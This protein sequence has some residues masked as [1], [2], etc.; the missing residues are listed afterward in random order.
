MK[1]SITLVLLTAWAVLAAAVCQADEAKEQELLAVLRSE[2]P[3][4][5]KAIACKLLA[6]HGSGAAAADLAPLLSN[7][8]L[9]S[10]ARI[11]LEAIPG[12]EADEALR[13]ATESLDGLLLV[14]VINSIGVR[15]DAQAV[16]SLAKQL[17][18][19]DAEVASAA[20]VA[21]GRIGNDG[22]VQTLRQALRNA[23]GEV[24]SA[25]AEGCVLSAERRL[26]EGK[27][28][29]AAE[30]YDE[31]RQAEVPQQRV[32]EATR[33]AIL[34]RGDEGVPLLLEQLRSPERKF[35]QMAL[36]TA[37]EF[38]GEQVDQALAQEITRAEPERAALII[39]AAADRPETV[40]L[41]AVLQA[42][43]QGAKPV[44]LSAI[45]ALQRVGDDSCLAALLKIATDADPELAQAA[46]DTL[47]ELPGD[48]IDARVVALLP[49][50]EGKM[51]PVLIEL[52][53]RRRIEATDTLLQ[54]LDHNDP[55]VRHA[56]LAA[57]GE[58]VD[59]KGLPVLIAQVV[60]PKHSQDVAAA[61]QALKTASVRM[62]DREACA[63]ELAAALQRSSSS[64]T[65][66]A[67]LETLGAVG[68]SKALATMA[69][70][71]K[72]SSPELQDAST[73]LL[74]EWM[75]ADAAPVLLDL[76]KSAPGEKYQV[77]A[78]RGYI[79]IARQ[80][81][82]PEQQRI[83]MC[84][85]ALAAARQTAEQKLVLDVLK[86]YP[87]RNTLQVALQAREIPAI[88][89]DAGLAARAIADNLASKGIDVREQLSNA[90]LR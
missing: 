46:K 76:A 44:R 48:N 35:F 2:A 33:G 15:R 29:E 63:A 13:K 74:G 86:R 51:Y 32:L 89:E 19:K 37:R 66:V 18:N 59:L 17:A 8:Q 40:V 10:W 24:R 20:A 68:G 80:F 39:Q 61:Q 55:A 62:P 64:D 31:V 50:A 28:D 16:E 41:A 47:A 71:A 65:E 82:L 60:T 23:P 49:E 75:T 26:T 14:G 25:V 43:Q 3:E 6:I 22:A 77:R 45:N 79:R 81:V 12:S 11:A 56:A 1:R 78:L 34:A 67:L 30:I 38:P 87:S 69:A 57:L 53:G 4:A 42:A 7:P 9:A 90:G 36:S 27:T 85:N 70:A 73:R 72:S 84:R 88:R 58:T 83:E 5:E 52:V 21:L 54:A